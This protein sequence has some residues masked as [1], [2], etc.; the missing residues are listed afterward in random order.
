MAASTKQYILSE[1]DTRGFWTA[2]DPLDQAADSIDPLGFL[3]SYVAL[4]VKGL[5]EKDA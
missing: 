3:A 4:E 5:V 1:P 2:Y